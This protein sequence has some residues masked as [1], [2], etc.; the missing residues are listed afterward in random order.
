MPNR[1][2]DRRWREYIEILAVNNPR[3][4]AP[5][6]KKKV[7]A[8]SVGEGLDPLKG[9]G[10]RTIFNIKKN[11][12]SW[13]PEQ[14]EPYLMF[15]WPESMESGALP[16]EAGPAALELLKLFIL[17]RRIRPTLR[18]T[19]LF[20]SVTMA[21]P[22]LPIERN[23][24]CDYGRSC[25]AELLYIEY[26]SASGHLG[27][28]SGVGRKWTLKESVEAYLI[29]RPWSSPTQKQLYIEAVRTG[30]IP[31]MPGE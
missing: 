2:I 31:S 6:L 22:D 14:A 7:E 28:E 9:P 8:C 3:M 30:R 27:P 18:L 12:K 20:W 26:K 1:K 15:R 24:I 23:I 17:G 11:V 29:Y 5:K 25:L 13:T 16:W 4:S 19:R 10:L 21:A